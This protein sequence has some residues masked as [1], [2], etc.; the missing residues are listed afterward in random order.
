MAWNEPGGTG[1][2]DPWGQRRKDQGPPDLDQMLKN[3][4]DRLSGLFGGFGGG[5]RGT[6]GGGGSEFINR[7]G[8]GLIVAV[9]AGL[10]LLS[11]LYI[12]NQGERGVELKFGKKNEVTGPGLHWHLPW[13]IE[14]VEKVNV[15]QVSTISIGRR[16]DKGSG[17]GIDSGF[18]LTEDENIVVVEFTVQYKIKDASDYKFNV[19]VPVS[20][21]VQA[22]ESASREVVGK[23]QLDFIITEGQLEV[24]EKTQ[25][26]LQ[27]ILDRYKSGIQIVKVQMQKV[28][29]PDEVKAAFDDATKAR[30]DGARIIKEA[31]A[32]SNDIIP[33]ARGAASR[34]IQEAQGYKAS[35]M[36]RAEGD[37]RRFA[38]IVGEYARYPGVTRDRMY[39]ETMEQVL[40]NTTKILIDQKG[41]SNVIYLP[42]DRM[43]QNSSGTAGA[44]PVSNLQPLPEPQDATPTGLRERERGRDVLRDR[45]AR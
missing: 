15:D 17:G 12:I 6:D 41:S 31:E 8:L 1:G 3:L 23:S 44:G 7:I 29:P 43:L 19:R 26:L 13:P 34:L 39:I 28:S 45:G 14:R 10:W 21:I 16:G 2:K 32:Y 5:G 33:R 22:M 37:A 24:S 30:E 35:V 40:S 4:R 38:S 25:K 36:A 42:L 11:G 9:A 20:T 27:E 18:M